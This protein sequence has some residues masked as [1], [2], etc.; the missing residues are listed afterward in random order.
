MLQMRC[1]RDLVGDVVFVCVLCLCDVLVCVYNVCD[2]VVCT[3]YV[4][5][6]HGVHC[7]AYMRCSLLYI[8]I[9]TD[10]IYT[11][12]HTHRSYTPTQHP[13]KVHHGQTRCF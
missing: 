1:S 5:G 8:C 2:G 6:T 11:S 3:Q 10:E 9:Y 13:H 4:C 7:Y 12:P